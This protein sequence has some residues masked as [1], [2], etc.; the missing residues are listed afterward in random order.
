MLLREGRAALDGGRGGRAPYGAGRRPRRTPAR[1]VVLAT[2]AGASSE[3]LAKLLDAY[4]A[5][6]GAAGVDIVLCAIG[7]QERMLRDGRADVALLHRP[8]D[9]L[10]GF[11]TEDLGTEG[12][13]LVLPAGH[14][15]TTR[16]HLVLADTQDVAGL[17]LPRWPLDDGSY[18]RGPRARGPRPHPAA[19][20]RRP[21]AA[22]AS[23][24]PTRSCRTCTRVWPPS[25]SSTPP[26]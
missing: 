14:P 4:A 2:K 17:P 7:E 9:D 16:P 23:S 11:D 13:V 21:W 6:P 25:A 1:P 18:A 26:P 3:L 19:P 5:E 12:Q 8:Y 15:L 10:A 20:A 22:P 24:C